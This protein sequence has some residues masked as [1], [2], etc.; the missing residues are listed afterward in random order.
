MFKT[1]ESVTEMDTFYLKNKKK[2]NTFRLIFT[3]LKQNIVTK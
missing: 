1:V 2:G 3:I